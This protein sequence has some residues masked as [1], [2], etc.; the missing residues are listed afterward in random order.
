[1]AR[2]AEEVRREL[3]S[4]RAGLTDAVA[5]LRTKGTELRA[6]LPVALGGAVASLVALRALT[7]RTRKP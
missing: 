5:D 6:K 7:R 4:E 2:S 3:R 1:M